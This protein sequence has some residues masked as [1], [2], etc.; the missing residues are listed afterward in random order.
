MHN[1]TSGDTLRV[2]DY[3][4]NVTGSWKTVPN[5][6]FINPRN[7]NCKYAIQY[8]SGMHLAASTQLSINL[9][10]NYPMDSYV[11]ELPAILDNFSP[12]LQVISIGWLVGGGGEPQSGR[13][14]TRQ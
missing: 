12:I 1:K 5:R 11:D 10:I 2:Q 14:N 8:I 4:I 9:G 13:L 3:S 6:T 7:T